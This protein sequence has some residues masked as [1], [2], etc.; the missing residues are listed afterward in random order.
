MH[1]QIWH[2]AASLARSA[3]VR[4]PH[5]SLQLKSESIEF[6][7]VSCSW[8]WSH[9]SNEF[10]IVTCHSPQSIWILH[11][12]NRVK[13]RCDGNLCLCIFQVLDGGTNFY[14]SS[15]DAILFLIHYFPRQ[16]QLETLPTIIIFTPQVRAPI[17]EFSQ[18]LSI[19]F[20]IIFSGMGKQ[21]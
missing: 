1:W 6:S 2:S 19:S 20:P 10:S 3:K 5:L 11:L 7:V 13:G 4:T 17:W 21:A 16:K 18:L 14:N 12:P 15:R 9:Y 8:N